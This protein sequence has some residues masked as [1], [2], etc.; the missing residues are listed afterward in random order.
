[1]SGHDYEIDLPPS[2]RCS[3]RSVAA[4]LVYLFN[5]FSVRK[6]KRA[7]GRCTEYFS[8]WVCAVRDNTILDSAAGGR[9]KGC[10][11]GCTSTRAKAQTATRPHPPA[12]CVAKQRG[13]TPKLTR[14][15]NSSV[16]RAQ[17]PA[18][19]H[20]RPDQQPDETTPQ[21]N[22]HYT[23]RPTPPPAVRRAGIRSPHT[24][25]PPIWDMQLLPK[26]HIAAE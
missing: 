21:R 10:Q 1:M 15:E 9:G 26:L 3:R 22:L 24:P 17:T 20:S 6:V 8:R 25:S 2:C 19:C 18:R 13:T 16:S 4:R 12:R 11:K 14:N 7:S 5:L 23:C